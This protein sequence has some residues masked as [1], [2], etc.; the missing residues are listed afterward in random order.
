MEICPN[1]Y[2]NYLKHKKAPYYDEKQ[3]V[4]DA[5]IETY[6]KHDGAV[7]YRMVKAYLEKQGILRSK[8]TIHK[9]MNKDLGLLCITRR[10]NPNY[11]YGETHNVFS[12]IIEQDF[13][14]DEINTK[15]LTDFTYLFLEN[16]EKRYN[17]SILDLHDR[18]IVASITD[19][20]ITA[21]LAKR[22]LEKALNSQPEI[23][24]V[25]ILHSDQGSQFTSNEFADYCKS[26]NV[27]QSMSKA[28]Y[29]YDNAPM[30]RYFNTLKN[31]CINLHKYA[32][33]EALYTAVEEFAYVTYN[34]L[35]PHS[36]NGYKTPFEARY[37][38]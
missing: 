36:S 28:G 27:T 21:D 13:E 12:N 11:E 26:V 35:R 20:H 9:Y 37:V 8:L 1:A 23:K 30:E 32:T 17:C 2:Y 38:A 33:E 16:G 7:G 31:D 22:T 15:W 24:G 5:I 18:S 3:S 29:P 4:Y 10:P 25:L 14:C 19:R 6:H 34:H